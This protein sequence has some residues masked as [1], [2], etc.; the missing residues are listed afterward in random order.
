MCF[1]T[2]IKQVIKPKIING[3]KTMVKAVLTIKNG[4]VSIF[5]TRLKND[6]MDQSSQNSFNSEKEHIAS[7]MKK[8]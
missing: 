8:E 3:T 6:G 7:E 1:K 5:K 4:M 2:G